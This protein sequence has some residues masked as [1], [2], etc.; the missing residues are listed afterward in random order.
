MT[1]TPGLSEELTRQE[2]RNIFCGH[3]ASM[4]RCFGRVPVWTSAYRARCS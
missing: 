2:F 3:G 4:P 1:A